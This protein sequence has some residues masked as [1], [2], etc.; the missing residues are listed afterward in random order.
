MFHYRATFCIIKSLKAAF[1]TTAT[2]V[3]IVVKNV[4]AIFATFTIVR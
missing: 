1:P 3:T 4:V 2:A